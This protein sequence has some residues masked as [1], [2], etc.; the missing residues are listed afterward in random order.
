MCYKNYYNQF[1]LDSIL[2]KSLLFHQ[3]KNK[4]FTSNFP[5]AFD[6]ETSSFYENNEKRAL[7]YMWSF[8]I[9]GKCIIGRTWD[10]FKRVIDKVIDFYELN[11][12]KKLVIYVH[13]LSFEF[14]F[15]AKL[16]EWTKVFALK[17][18]QVV[19]CFYN[20]V[21]FRC[22]YLLSGY[23]LDKTAKN[24]TK[25]KVSKLVGS[26]DYEKIRH[27]KTPLTE[28]EIQ[29]S[30]ND[31]LVV[32][33]YIQ[34]LIE[35]YKYID[36]LPLTKTGF[37]RKEVRKLCNEKNIKNKYRNLMRRLQLNSVPE[38]L[39]LQRAFSGGFTHASALK[40]N[41]V[42]SNVASY[43]FTS[44]YPYVMLSE[45]FPMSRFEKIENISNEDFRKSLKYYCCVF[46]ISFTNLESKINFEYYLS[47]SRSISI[48]NKEV[49]N[50]RIVSAD[51]LDITL[52]NIDFEIVEKCYTFKD[53]K[54]FNFRRAKKGYLPKPIILSILKFYNDK[55]KLKDIIGKEVDYLHGKENLNSIYGMT[56][57]NII[58][59]EITFNNGEWNTKE[60]NNK[61]IEKIIIK[62]NGSLNR[63]LFYAWGVFVTAY[64]RKNLWTG[65]FEYKNDYIYSDTD[66]I[67][68]LNDDKHQDYINNYNL[69]VV[70]KLKNVANYY[71][72][73]FSL[74]QPKTIEN[75]TK[76]IGIWSYEG[77]YDKFKTLGAKRYLYFKDNNYNLTVSGLNKKVAIPYIINKSKELNISPFDFFT[78]DMY[79]PKDFTGCMVHTYI[80]NQTYGIV[81]DYLGQRYNYYEKSSIHLEKRE[82]SLSISRQ[83]IEFLLK[84]EVL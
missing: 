47:E 11:E 4:V 32:M 21:E 7:M 9:N 55:T 24:L 38:F 68:V 27:S 19:Y 80:D 82:Y 10:E 20:G 37:V 75:K 54:V 40:V 63:F 46:D 28:E 67:K 48:E 2:D 17:S 15:I 77:I 41:K 51:K 74:F 57:T 29:Y 13:N 30:I 53:F 84:I 76:L 64:A 79:I 31:I 61:E 52:T 39:Q 83:F 18:R 6:I 50:G 49:A 59:D 73:D 71:N 69:E 42:Y 78:D 60:L 43:D 14:G 70:E 56:V 45:L 62:N 33:S 1:N 65:I 23:S 36:Y 25:Y 35:S 34:E 44:S 3:N 66:S 58:R 81:T 5:C 72:L 22:S 12:Y 8:G 26:L 16:F